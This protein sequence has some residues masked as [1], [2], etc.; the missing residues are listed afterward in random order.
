[1]GSSRSLH[2]DNIVILCE[3]TKTEYQYFCS[4]RDYLNNTNSNRFSDIKIVPVE[5]EM[6]NPPGSRKKRKLKRDNSGLNLNICYYCL[7]EDSAQLYEQYKS[8]PTRFVRETYLFME[9][10]RY[11]YGW[12][13]YDHDDHPDRQNADV[14]ARK[15]GVKIAFSSRCFEEWLLMHFERNDTIFTTSECKDTNG[16]E[17][18]CGIGIPDSCHGEICIGGC[19]REKNFIPNYKKTDVSNLFTNYTLPRLEQSLVNSAWLNHLE[20]GT[21]YYDRRRYTNVGDLILFLLDRNDCVEWK[22]FGSSFSFRG[23]NL[24]IDKQDDIIVLKN[25]GKITCIT[26]DVAYYYN[27]GLQQLGTVINK[28]LLTSGQ[29]VHCDPIPQGATLICFHDSIRKIVYNL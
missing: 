5:S 3:G 22:V 17:K 29:V 2:Q 6:V 26:T 14:Q 18:R 25:I 19:L 24:C 20:D 8:E 1:M 27:D 9:R 7:Q 4:I 16:N 28:G 15:W 13:V 11:K 21:P 10:G 12:A 23:T